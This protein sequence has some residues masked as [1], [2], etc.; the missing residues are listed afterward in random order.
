MD[1]IRI[2]LAR[3]LLMQVA[4]GAY[5]EATLVFDETMKAFLSPEKLQETWQQLEIQMG[6]FQGQQETR[7][8]QV[9][10]HQV[11]FLNCLF[12]NGNL[13][14]L[15]AFNEANQVSGLSFNPLAGKAPAE[16]DD[17]LPPYIQPE[18]F[19]EI[20]IM[21]GHGEWS[22]PGTLTLPRGA[23]P[24]PAVVLVHGSGPQDRDE[25]LGP[26]RPF[27]D[28]A[29]GLASHQIAVLRYEKRTLAYKEKVSQQFLE[30]TTV[31][32][33]TI[34]DALAAVRQLRESPQIHSKQIFVLGHSLGGYLL[35]RIAA[36][37]AAIAGL[38]LLAASS[39]PLEDV[40]LDQISYLLS[41][42]G[43]TTPE[44]QQYLNTLAQQV[45]RVKAPD[46]QPTT[47]ASELPLNV[48]AP[49]WL[50]LRAYQPI[51][52]ARQLSQPMLILQAECDYQ[53]TMEDFQG[54]KEGLA[55]RTD[56]LFKSYPGLYHLF[57]P[58]PDGEM[59]TP[60]VYALPGHVQAAVID[61]IIH[62]IEEIAAQRS[63]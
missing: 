57:M 53:V 21:V 33:E 45:A 3:K 7:T 36:A 20:E 19:S 47:P 27:R 2:E 46:L 40:I 22:L 51:E 25:T 15:V 56:V 43:N 44:Q 29:W 50:D 59:A 28:L 60:V 35:P 58:T 54:W 31:Q 18:A 37:D 48:P 42:Q 34:D 16:A 23:G 39:R 5:S 30:A 63:A 14:F 62:W 26:N 49:Y 17:E 13:E 52:L 9:Q 24:F 8:A 6:S 1:D 55:A 38:I 12:A 61:D 32:E 41:T 11:V 10:N 4:Q